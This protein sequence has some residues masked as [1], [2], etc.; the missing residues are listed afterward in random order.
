MKNTK[1]K[2]KAIEIRFHTSIK[3][4]KKKKHLIVSTESYHRRFQLNKLRFQ[5]HSENIEE[6]NP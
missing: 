3:K 5:E 4:R 2:I 6:L 1:C